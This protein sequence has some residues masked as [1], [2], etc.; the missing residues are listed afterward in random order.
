MPTPTSSMASSFKSAAS[1]S[2]Q[3]FS[4][5]LFI[6]VS[7]KCMCCPLRL[8]LAFGGLFPRA[9]RNAEL[10]FMASHSLDLKPKTTLISSYSATLSPSLYKVSTFRIHLPPLPPPNLHIIA[11]ASGLQLTISPQE[12]AA[13]SPQSQPKT[14]PT[15]QQA[16]T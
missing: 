16:T 3:R 10:S 11:T 5:L 1:H 4:P 12:P 9:K 15:R 13:A 14:T 2:L 7:Q 8:L 6:S